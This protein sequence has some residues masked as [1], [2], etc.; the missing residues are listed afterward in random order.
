MS[1]DG[2]RTSVFTFQSAV[3]SRHVLRSLEELRHKELLCD[4]TV[5]VERRSF[6]AHSSV[7]ASCSDYF[8]TRLTNHSRPNPTVRLP[9]EVTVEGFEPLLQFAYTAKLHFTKEN[10]LEIHRCAEFL[11]FQNLDKACFEFLVPKFSAGGVTSKKVEGKSKGLE[12]SRTICSPN[13][14]NPDTGEDRVPQDAS[15]VM[16][17]ACATSSEESPKDCPPITNDKAMQLDLSTLYARST[18]YHMGDGQDQFCLQNCGP[19]LPS[20]SMAAAEVCPFLSISSTGDNEKLHSSPAGDILAMEDDFQKDLAMDVHCEPPTDKDLDIA[21]ITEGHFDQCEGP[22]MS[23]SDA[24]HLCPLNS[25]Q[26]S[27]D[28]DSIS[29][30][31][32]L[33]NIGTEDNRVFD[34]NEQTFPELTPKDCATERSTVE[35]EVAEHLAKGFWPDLSATLNETLPLDSIDQSSAGNGS[36]FHWLKHLDLGAAPDDCPFLR[37]LSSND[38]QTSGG[39]T[40]SK[41]DTEDSPCMSPINSRENSECESDGDCAQCDSS[42]QVQEVDLPFPVE[43][44][45]SMTRRA[46]LQML[47]REQLTPEQLEFV[48]DVR[49]RSKNRMAAQR[50]RKR[51]LDCIYRLEGEIKKLRSE[52]EKLLHDHNQLKLSI[53]D[54][55]QNLSGLCQSL[56]A[57]GA[58]QSE[59]LR[60][61]ARYFSSDCPTSVLLTPMASPSLAGPDQ[62]AHANSSLD[63]FLADTCPEGDTAALRTPT[64]FLQDNVQSTDTDP[65]P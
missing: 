27:G 2:P 28:L 40:L 32:D 56:S 64:A 41:E 51:K 46:F 6:R 60:A 16:Q 5:E 1:V 3:H 8:Y 52:K 43:Q 61:L 37:D 20:S 10:I 50:C 44:I 57:D 15:T 34:S 22:L 45:S 24:S 62:D 63:T 14:Q 31:P 19:P 9:D 65:A 54:V 59:Q 39:D 36:D 7:L 13:D 53:E 23:P 49:R 55:R 33:S 38:R 35:R 26:S 21:S 17:A 12:R 47:K 30:A 18:A 11:G 4:V 25:A 42:E 48:Q 29:G 58:P